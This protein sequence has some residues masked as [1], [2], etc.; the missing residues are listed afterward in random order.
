MTETQG[1]VLITGTSSGFG[2][3]VAQAFA[4]AGYAVVVQGR[5]EARLRAVQDGI[6]KKG[7]GRCSM[8]IAD[9]TTED[10]QDAVRAALRRE[11]VGIVVNNAAINPELQRGA[12]ALDVGDRSAIIAT[13]TTAAIALCYA[14][15]EHFTA[16]NGGTI[17]N[18]NSV[19]GLRGSSHEPLYA[20]SKFGLRGFSESVKEKW[21]QRGVK[22][23][24][25]Y[26]GAL[27]A[28]MS[29]ARPDVKDLIDPQ[30]LAVLLVGLCATKSFFVK[31][32]N[33][34]RTTIT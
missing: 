23:I 33:V 12:A 14:A 20:A 32:L 17:V 9:L 3:H 28:G 18:I 2:A 1:T 29:S 25:V 19:A 11:H 21:L 16:G 4:R 10:G 15:F 31:E 5:D 24:D 13:N 27:A 26:A 34:R 7:K 8:V 30:E 6:L 22:M